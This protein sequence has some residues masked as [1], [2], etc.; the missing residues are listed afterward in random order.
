MRRSTWYELGAPLNCRQCVHESPKNWKDIDTREWRTAHGC[1]NNR[2]MYKGDTV[3]GKDEARYTLNGRKL[4]HSCK[5]MWEKIGCPIWKNIREMRK[6][7][8]KE[9]C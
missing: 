5:V 8:D 6:Q 7:E 9:L 4:S 3:C 2:W 1:I